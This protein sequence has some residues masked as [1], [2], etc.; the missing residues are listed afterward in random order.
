[1][2][3]RRLLAVVAI[4]LMT[5]SASAETAGKATASPPQSTAAP[6]TKTPTKAASPK[7]KELSYTE[8]L[9]LEMKRCMDAWD[10]GTSMTKK[11]W[12][13]ICQRT[14]NERLP[15]KRAARSGTAPPKSTR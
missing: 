4:P 7:S 9:K 11:K 15:H 14:L 3:V 1:M 12:R 5:V 8:E 13:E 10:A 6:A 2:F